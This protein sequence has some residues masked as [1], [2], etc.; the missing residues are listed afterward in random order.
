[1]EDTAE[2]PTG[3]EGQTPRR[4]VTVG[5]VNDAGSI[6]EKETMPLGELPDWL[7]A[8]LLPRGEEGS[9]CL[10]IQ[11]TDEAGEPVEA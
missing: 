1:M 2:T 6:S 3:V 4:F 7:K 10:D 9:V 11:L 8:R 5:V